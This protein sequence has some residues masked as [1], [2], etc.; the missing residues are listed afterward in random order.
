MRNHELLAFICETIK[1]REHMGDM[2]C[3]TLIQS[4]LEAHRPCL[5]DPYKHAEEEQAEEAAD[6]MMDAAIQVFDLEEFSKK[7]PLPNLNPAEC[8]DWVRGLDAPQTFTEELRD[9]IA[10]EIEGIPTLEET[11]WE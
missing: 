5:I 1:V 7:V 3:L 9:S 10:D 8:A 2:A 6:E 11:K 4:V